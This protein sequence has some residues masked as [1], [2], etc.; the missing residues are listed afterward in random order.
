MFKG[1]RWQFLALLT[2]IVIFVAAL[3]SRGG[4]V[5]PTPTATPD[6]ATQSIA[7]TQ[8]ILPTA[9]PTLSTGEQVDILPTPE[10]VLPPAAND[11]V[12]TY[13]EALIGQVQRLNPLYASLNTVDADITALI[14]E[15]LTRIN[16]FGE[17]VGA[18]AREWI[19]S[20]DSLEYVFTLRD[21][22]LWQDGTPFNADDV[23]YTMFVLRSIAFDGQAALTSFWRTVETEKLGDHLVRFRLTQPY[24][25]FLDALRIGILPEHAFTGT[26]IA[27]LSA[28]PFNLSPIG[29]GPYQLEALRTDGTG[30]IKQIDLRVAPNYRL[31]PEGETGYAVD[32]VSFRL[33][34]D[35]DSALSALQNGE[36][37]GIAARSRRERRPLIQQADAGRV[38][39]YNG[40]E[41]SVGMI[42]FNWQ[43]AG[44]PFTQETARQ[45]LYRVLD[46]QGLVQRTMLTEALP[47][48]SPMLISSWVYE[49]NLPQI[50]G[51]VNS[52]RGLWAQVQFATPEPEPTPEAEATAADA[53]PEEA[54]AVE[55]STGFNINMLVL[56]DSTQA[57]LAQAV[58][59]A[60]AQ[61]GVLVSVETADMETYTARLDSGDFDAALVEF[62][63][64]GTA[65][66]D[67][68]AFWHQ[69]QY[70]DGKNYGSVDDRVTSEILEQ[71]RRDPNGI[72]R[73]ELYRRFQ[74]EFVNRALA[75]PMYYP[76][77]SY[78]LSPVVSGVQLGFIG[79][80]PDR[81][82]SIQ[83][84]VITR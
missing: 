28:H 9:T 76:I 50:G 2:A 17:P 7:Q 75:V 69:G 66:P 65:D 79:A 34:A 3:L 47:A 31:R 82:K 4:S 67:V 56:D 70:P 8:D 43:R 29:T 68:Y 38:R 44:M 14:F 62:S 15:G 36:V 21:D 19:V 33:Y 23:V 73:A 64:F 57:A 25:G 51:D 45:A 10:S 58:A 40:I 35:Y 54:P 48:N 11:D 81:F 46:R 61:L 78:A 32:R 80:P 6:A 39:V 30:T 42:V 26:D 20:S 49:S 59:E 77:Y 24:A 5:S 1:Y 18:L 41:P 71:A 53:P 83:D 16:E 84:W 55:Q 63:T 74:R 60:W 52:A 37:D 12:P 13:R 27:Q 72:N 22:V